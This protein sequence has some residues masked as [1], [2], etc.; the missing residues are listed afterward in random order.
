MPKRVLV[1]VKLGLLFKVTSPLA[2]Q[3]KTTIPAQGSPS[4][5]LPNNDRVRIQAP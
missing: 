5:N 1:G 4:E 2:V 3:A